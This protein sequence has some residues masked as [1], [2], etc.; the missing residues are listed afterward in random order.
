MAEGRIVGLRVWLQWRFTDGVRTC[1]AVWLVDTATHPDFQVLGTFRRLTTSSL[2][3]LHEQGVAPVLNTPNEQS[4][5]GYLKMCWEEVGKQPVAVR[6]RSPVAA[7]TAMRAQVVPAERG[8]QPGDGRPRRGGITMTVEERRRIALHRATAECWGEE[9]A[10][11]LVELVAPSGHE[12]ATR[13]DTQGVLEVMA[14]RDERWDERFVAAEARSDERQ[15]EFERRLEI[16]GG[17]WQDRL[18]ASDARTEASL[19]GL[20][21]EFERSLQEAMTRQAR[22]VVTTLVATVVSMSGLSISL[23]AMLAGW[24]GLSADGPGNRGPVSST[25]PAK[26]RWRLVAFRQ[27]RLPGPAFP[28]PRDPRSSEVSEPPVPVRT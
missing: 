13:A 26:S 25:P 14:A 19:Q 6:F 16:V 4:N 2:E 27:P 28:T 5:P 10:D 18:A 21:A 20:R 8:G 11:T 7:A 12:L 1:D 17:A 23:A 22:V 9:V 24:S 15:G 3:E